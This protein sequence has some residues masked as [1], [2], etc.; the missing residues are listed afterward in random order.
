[1]Y[2]NKLFNLNPLYLDKWNQLEGFGVDILVVYNN[3]IPYQELLVSDYDY[4]KVAVGIRIIDVKSGDVIQ[5]E[6]YDKYYSAKSNKKDQNMKIVIIAAVFISILFG[7]DF[8]IAD[9]PMIYIY[10]FVSY[11]TTTILLH[12]GKDDEVKV[13]F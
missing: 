4:L 9:P 1:M 6:N 12:G 5:V 11:D 7:K 2:D 10:H 13:K 3:L 8:T